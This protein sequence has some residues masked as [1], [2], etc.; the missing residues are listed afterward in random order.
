MKQTSAKNDSQ[1]IINDTTELFYA[2]LSF[3]FIGTLNLCCHTFR[4]TFI[5]TLSK[6]LFQ[7]QYSTAVTNMSSN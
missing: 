5:H 6:C 7:D 3:R 1:S 4:T 2:T